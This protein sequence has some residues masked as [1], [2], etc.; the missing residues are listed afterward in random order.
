V[1]YKVAT[2]HWVLG[3]YMLATWHWVLVEYMLTT[4]HW[5]LVDQCIWGCP[6]CTG[7]SW[8]GLSYVIYCHTH[9]AFAASYSG[10]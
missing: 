5:V 10:C 8:S 7:I 9:K 6:G 2:W 1:E 3:E 4:W